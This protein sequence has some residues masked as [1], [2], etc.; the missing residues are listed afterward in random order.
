MGKIKKILDAQ[1]QKKQEEEIVDE[2][3]LK[4]FN[5]RI[6]NDNGKLVCIT[7]VKAKTKESALNKVSDDYKGKDYS[8]R[9]I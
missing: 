6:T 2:N 5:V 3:G 9:I 1:K 8:F 4:E 7:Y